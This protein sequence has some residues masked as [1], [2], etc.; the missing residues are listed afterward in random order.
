MTSTTTSLFRAEAIAHRRGAQ[1]GDV[2]AVRTAPLAWLTALFALLALALVLFIGFGEYTRKARVVGFLAPSQGLVKVVATQAGTV[3]EKR[4]SEGQAVKQGDILFVLAAD[5]ASLEN[6]DARAAAIANITAR[7]D[8]LLDELEKQDDL[9]R[10]RVQLLQDRAT[11]LAGEVRQ[12][13]QEVRLREQRLASAQANQ[14]KF[15]EL[16]ARHFVSEL[17][18]REKQDEVL[19]HDSAL[20]ALKRNRLTLEQDATNVQAEIASSRFEFARQRAQLDRAISSQEQELTEYQARRSIVITAPAA[21]T[22]TA[23]LVEKGQ[24]ATTQAPLLSI[25]PQ[26][27][28]LQAHLLVP[29]RSIGFIARGQQVALRYEAFPYQRFGSQPGEV[30]EISQNLIAPDEGNFPVKLDEPAYRVVVRPTRQT[31]QAYQQAVPLQAG[32]LLDADVKL[33]KR[34]LFQWLLD[35]L[36]SLT[37]A[38]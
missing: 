3:I 25:L 26:G 33:E 27:S 13:E 30:S 1:M 29:S 23:I 15:R 34:R 32:M 7:R 24:T 20:Q 21:G 18:M 19:D 12:L 2:L 6:A 38:L 14:E 22:A 17:Q 35:P 37:G 8:S 9:N 5:Q 11:T 16:F 36:F 31:L 4:V 10:I 28:D